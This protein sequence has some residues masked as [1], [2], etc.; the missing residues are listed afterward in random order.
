MSFFSR[1]IN[2]VYEVVEDDFTQ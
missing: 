2:K 1:I